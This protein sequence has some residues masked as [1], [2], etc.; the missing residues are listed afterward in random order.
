MERFY[1]STAIDYPNGAPHIGHA[2]EKIVTDAHA[3]WQ[4][5]MGKETYFLTGTDE[6]GQKLQESAKLEGKE[7]IDFVDEN[8]ALFH[9]FCN[10][11]N[12]SFDDFIRTTEERHKK[13]ACDFWK[14]LEVKGDLYFGKYSGQYCISCEN[15]YT[16]LQA[17][18]KICPHHNKALELKEEDGY[19]FKMSQYQDWIINTIKANPEFIVPQSSHKEILSRLENETIR[20]VAFSRPNNGWGIPVPGQEEKFVMYTW[21]DALVNYYSALVDKNLEPKFWP[22]DVHVIGKDIAWFHCVIW[23]CMLHALEIP[24]P[25]QVYVHGMVLGADGKKMS[26]S[27]NNGVAPYDML[28]KYPLDTLRYYLLRGIPATSDGAFVEEDLVTRNNS[29]LGNDYGNLIMRV[30]KLSLKHLPEMVNAEGLTLELTFDDIIEKMKQSMNKREHNR[31][32]DALWEGVNRANQ[33]VNEK[34]PWKLKNDPEALT[35]VV[36]NCLSGIHT[37]ASL[38]YPFLP[39]TGAKTLEYLDIGFRNFTD[40]SNLCHTSQTPPYTLTTPE[41]LFPKIEA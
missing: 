22:A 18:D 28:K 40:E 30:I 9:K 14:R 32:L 20:D 41:A 2:Y 27:L 6:N 17:P 10:D 12:I 4:R 3:R 11:L 37:L 24:L 23:P 31:A 7:T 21:C 19:F 8:V 13:V 39:E 29:E 15:F 25:K 38:L 26:K 35:P 1:I 33:Y 5:L 34:A 16:E 36:Y